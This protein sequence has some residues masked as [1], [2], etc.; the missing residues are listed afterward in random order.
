[1]FTDD[2]PNARY[3]PPQILLLKLPLGKMLSK[4]ASTNTFLFQCKYSSQN[5]SF[6]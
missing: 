5:V 6:I 2:K 3:L 4:Q 1:M